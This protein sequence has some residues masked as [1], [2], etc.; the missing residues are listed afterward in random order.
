M[1]LSSYERLR[2]YI[3]DESDIGGLSDSA[4]NKRLLL[5]WLGSISDRV[6]QFLH[7]SI[8]TTARTK[9]FD[10]GYAQ[11]EFWVLG[12]PISTIT[13]IK[14]DTTGL[15]VGDESTLT[16]DSD[17]HI[18]TQ[19]S[20]VV[21]LYNPFHTTASVNRGLQV[22]YTGGL[23]VSAVRSVFVVASVTSWVV[24][25][26]CI[27]A[28]SNS[29]GI[30]RAIGAASLTIEVLYGVF[31]VAETIGAYVT[32]DQQAAAVVTTTITSKEQ[33]ALC[34]SFPGIVGAVEGEIRYMWKHKLDFE[35]NS[36]QRDGKTIRRRSKA[37]ASLQAETKLLLEPYINAT[38]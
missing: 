23:A 34:E 5:T 16:A 15:F 38:L 7:R 21:L 25:Q 29:V 19:G 10:V 35:D 3:G 9:Y 11:D 26:F 1:L 18:G 13:T 6:E 24:G 33:T 8:E 28:T 32:E 31:E 17:Y 22:V 2:R 4:I 12:V 20:S 14:A 27:G 37:R 36:S 30:V